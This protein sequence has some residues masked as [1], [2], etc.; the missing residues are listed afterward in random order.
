MASTIDDNATTLSL[1]LLCVLLGAA[2]GKAELVRWKLTGRVAPQDCVIRAPRLFSHI[3]WSAAVLLAVCNSAL[4]AAPLQFQLAGSIEV[5][6][7]VGPLPIG[8]V[9]GGQ[10]TGLLSYDPTTEDALPSD[11]ERGFYPT[12]DV[13][14][15]FLE[16]TA[17]AATIT[18]RFPLFFVVGNDL[19]LS[20]SSFPPYAS[21][22][23]DDSFGI[24]TVEFNANFD[25]PLITRL[26]LI[27]TSDDRG[28]LSDD[29]LPDDASVFGSFSP[30]Y[31]EVSTVQFDP[32]S[33][34][35]TFR[36]HVESIVSV[37]EPPTFTP[38]VVTACLLAM[39][40]SG[41]ARA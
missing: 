28:A 39:V 34:Q 10:F 32:R 12:T 19:E 38:F 22:R 13:S 3:R 4:V 6:R 24:R 30:R 27:W 18:N 35:F 15:N 25:V 2:E 11:Q 33:Y 23:P 37:P 1:A 5:V 8:V 40:R 31:I 29:A 14:A 17:G 20:D 16:L 9:D 36:A 21:D 26:S 7:Q 41:W